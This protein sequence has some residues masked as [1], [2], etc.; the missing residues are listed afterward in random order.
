M[1]QRAT[2]QPESVRSAH[3]P[4]PTRV[5]PR[6]PGVALDASLRAA[7]EPRL[8]H[9]F[10][11]IRIHAD[12]EAAELARNA[13]AQ[14]YTA[15]SH[16]V[17][18]AG[19]YRPGAAAGQRLL[20]HELAHAVQQSRHGGPGAG[21]GARGGTHERE[22]EGAAHALGWGGLHR[23]YASVAPAV[24]WHGS[25]LPR[26]AAPALSPAGALLQR[27]ELTYDDGPDSAGNT[28]L[29]LDALNAAG[30]RA[31]FYLVGKRIIQGENWRV[32]FDIAAA[33]HW[34]GNHAYDWDDTTDNHQ[35]LHGSAEDRALKILNTEWAIRDALIRGRD[36]AKKTGTWTSIPAGS[37]TQ[38]EDVIAHGTGRFRTP[39]FRSKWWKTDGGTTLAAIASVNTVL[40]AAG[41][42]P[43][44]ITEVSSWGLTHEGVTVDP[45]DW[46]KGRTK[47]E[48]ETAVTSG[49][50][51]DDDSILLHSRLKA[52]AEATPA[53]AADI[54]AKNLTFEPT[55]QGKL[56][57]GLPKA[58][59]ANLSTISDPPTSAEIAQARAFLRRMIPSYGGFLA[60]SVALGILQMAQR[61]GKAEV[62]AFVKEI[63]DTQVD[64]AKYGKV[65][66]ANWM[67]DNPE[68][69]LFA[70]F[71][72]NWATS[73]PFPRIKGV[74]Y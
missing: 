25:A 74:T 16:V 23:R 67:M 63:R 43:L 32:V 12:A 57:S 60:G 45:E 47:D 5:I 42:R 22:A 50:T 3:G 55:I 29:V 52:S 72:E 61:A 51:S 33:G 24:A 37:R 66:L 73:K 39:G 31:T 15:G 28:R 14:A 17:F 62:D 54:K 36:E 35:F 40:R 30:A 65:P 4:I 20:V 69:R 46:R 48:I 9:D 26:P 58:G 41:L 6:S 18:G 2:I 1:S 11:S 59:F 34:L 21:V 38:I 68:W 13:G 19:R 70:G 8:G 7:L 53:I 44:E 64:T 49:T 56:G 27:V 71:Y 10:G